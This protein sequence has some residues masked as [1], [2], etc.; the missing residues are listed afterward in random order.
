MLGDGIPASTIRQR[1]E[2]RMQF[3]REQFDVE[4]YWECEIKQMMERGVKVIRNMSG[5]VVSINMK[6]F[7]DGLEDTGPI[8]LADAF[9]G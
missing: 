7:M 9:H 5:E 6:E 2:E 4:E 8:N 1:H 3:L